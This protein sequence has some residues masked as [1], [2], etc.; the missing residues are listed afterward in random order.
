MRKMYIVL[1]IQNKPA[2]DLSGKH[3]A[4]LELMKKLIRWK[5][6]GEVGVREMMMHVL[7]YVA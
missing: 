1:L 5:S 3:N 7:I 6:G 4:Y 2:S